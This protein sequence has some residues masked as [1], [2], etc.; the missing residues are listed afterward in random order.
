[1]ERLELLE[2]LVD[3]KKVFD[4]GSDHGLLAISL[5][6]NHE[7]VASDIS[8]SSIKKMEENVSKAKANVKV[9]LSDGLDN[10]DITK[11][12]TVIIA[13][14]GTYTILKILKNNID[15]VPNTLI[16]Q[17]NNNH[18]ILRKEI[19]KLGYYIDREET[20]YQNRWY[21]I[22]RFKKG[23]KKYSKI[24]YLVGPNPSKEY[25]NFNLGLYVKAL[26][27][28][29]YKYFIKRYNIKR[30]IKQLKKMKDM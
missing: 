4:V 27:K 30:I 28:I 26:D 9:V 12:D 5:S 13:G 16:I 24:D 22:I 18:D 15:K 1:M 25:L 29:P 23:Y 20:L 14:M 11:K 10:L 2:S 17:A 19:T 8:K 21:T 3:T 6:K 7:V